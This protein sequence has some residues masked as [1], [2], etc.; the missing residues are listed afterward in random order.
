MEFKIRS[1]LMQLLMQETTV[2]NIKCD[3]VLD[4]IVLVC[5]LLKNLGFSMDEPRHLLKEIEHALS[6]LK[7]KLPNMLYQDI[8]S[9]FSGAKMAAL[10]R[11]VRSR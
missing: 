5:F 6:M 11:Y 10:K 9:G 2:P 8:V 4:D 3:S 1:S 7:A